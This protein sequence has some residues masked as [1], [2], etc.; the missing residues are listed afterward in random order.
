[1]HLEPTQ[2][3]CNVLSKG[4]PGPEIL[5]KGYYVISQHAL[6]RGA[7]GPNHMPAAMFVKL[8]TDSFL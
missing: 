5:I 4:D 7:T 1:M 2:H 3:T 6:S 8:A